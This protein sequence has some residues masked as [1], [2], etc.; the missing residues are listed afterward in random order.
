G[1][2]ILAR[3]KRKASHVSDGAG[4]SPRSVSRADRLRRVLY[5]VKLVLPGKLK[6]RVHFSAAA[7]Q[8]HRHNCLRTRRQLAFYKPRLDVE[9]VRFNVD[10][11]GYRADAR[12]CACGGKKGIRS[13]NDLI[14]ITDSSRHKRCQKRI[15]ARRHTNGKLSPAKCGDFVLESGHFRT[16]DEVLGF[17]NAVNR[18]TDLVANRRILGFQIE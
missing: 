16:E 7:K 3:E 15:G 11:N 6:D 5:H 13:S 17:A 18:R 8:V 12:D 4:L 2:E 14:S 9:C 10:E 1:S